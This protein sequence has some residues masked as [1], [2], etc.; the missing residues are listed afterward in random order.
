MARPPSLEIDEARLRKQLERASKRLYANA[1]GVLT[2]QQQTLKERIIALAPK[3]N[4]PSPEGHIVD[5]VYVDVVQRPN[6]P[7]LKAG[8][9]KVAHAV[10]VEFGTSKAPAQPFLRPA[11]AEMPGFIKRRRRR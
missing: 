3:G 10:F 7:V 8:V 11:L 5:H 4:R 1:D 2:D 9:K 6:G